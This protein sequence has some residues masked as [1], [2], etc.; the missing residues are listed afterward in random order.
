MRKTL[1]TLPIILFALAAIGQNSPLGMRYQAVIRDADG[2]IIADEK[3]TAKIEMLS[4][5]G[6]SKVYYE[7]QHEATSNAFGLINLTIGEG[8]V[9]S[10]KY[11][12][13]PW[14]EEN[15]WVRT[16]I[17]RQG[18]ADFN[19]VTTNQLYSVPYAHYATKAGALAEEVQGQQAQ[20][21]SPSGGNTWSLKG[22]KNADT[23]NDPP[24]MGTTDY[25]PVVFITDNEERMRIT[26]NGIIEIVGDLDVGEDA[27]IGMD[28]TVKQDVFLNTEGGSTAINGPTTIGGDD[29]NSATFTGDVQMDKDLNVDGAST[30]NGETT[31]GGV[32]M[33]SA[34]FTGN[35]QLDKELNVDGATTLNGQTTIENDLSVNGKVNISDSLT[36]RGPTTFDIAV[37]G[38][39]TEQTSYPVLIKGSDQ[40]LAIDLTPAT[41]DCLTS[42]RGNNYISFWRDGEQKGRIEG[43]GR[44]DL[45]PTGLL[46]LLISIVSDPSSAP[47]G[48]G[49]GPEFGIS[50]ANP[51]TNFGSELANII[52]LSPGSFPSFSGG[53]LP[54]LD[55]GSLPSICFSC[56]SFNDGSLPSLDP[57]S[58]PNLVGGA[59]PN[60]S[61]NTPSFTNPFESSPL[62]S[63]F[64]DLFE[65]F[66]PNNFGGNPAC[67]VEEISPAQ[68]AW[69]LIKASLMTAN[70]YPPQSD[71]TNF[72]SQI[73]SNYTLDVL[74]G[75]ISTLSSAVTFL[76]SV[77]SVLDPEDIFSEG[78]DLIA[79]VTS[80]VIY[81]SY[82]DINI[83]V[84]YESGAGDY[85]EW[86]LRADPNELIQPGDVVGVVGGR[87]S[88]K[89]IH[90]DK[91]LVVSTSPMLLGNMPESAVEEQLSEKIAFVGQVP[92]KVMGDVK[93][94]DYILPSGSGNGIAIAVAP[95]DMLA[96]DYQRIVGIAWE[97]S[98][99]DGFINLINTAVGINHNDMSKVIE[100]MQFTLNHIQAKLKELDPSFAAHEYEVTIDEFGGSPLDYNVSATHV[101]KVKTYFKDK[102]YG[103]DIEMLAD[104]RERMVSEAGVN[105]SEVPLIDFILRNPE[106]AKDLAREYRLILEDMVSVRD[107]MLAGQSN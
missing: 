81:G 64:D 86:L 33:N 51:L 39:Q 45:D 59:L 47:G 75:G 96:R 11:A 56:P 38:L 8:D 88:K 101:S 10:G 36:V 100:Q 41:E 24:V 78:V 53:S 103:S 95:E 14:S 61:F 42:H 89:F 16:S 106:E 65:N 49:L 22:N 35:V 94:G 37:D 27:I 23:H 6:L 3:I 31:I 105:L 28:L 26:E 99:D 84:A 93:I 83:G 92:V 2:S 66:N 102:A 79:N 90:A 87:V 77:G 21:G 107:E 97:N 71:A 76:T 20:G 25:L 70:M 29:M 18:A 34:T 98:S 63:T 74:L 17:K 58:F 85:A 69:S 4:L 30:L 7:E 104:V 19:I 50:L 80:L 1:L 68:T 67:V 62:T 43:M 72:E 48:N 91:F 55:P 73:F 46:S 15:I 13:I 82:A 9:V 12:L 52:D 40:G 5:D 44:A 60:I 57:G 32:D 54:D